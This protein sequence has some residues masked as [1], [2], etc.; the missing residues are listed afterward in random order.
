MERVSTMLCVFQVMSSEVSGL[1]NPAAAT[2]TGDVSAGEESSSSTYG[3]VQDNIVMCPVPSD[4]SDTEFTA[5][6]PN[7][8]LVRRTAGVT[9]D[10]IDGRSTT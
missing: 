3:A 6:D 5:D 9:I 4:S 2:S 1:V 7:R 8:Q 10:E